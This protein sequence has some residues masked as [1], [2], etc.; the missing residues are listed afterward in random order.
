VYRLNNIGADRIVPL[1]EVTIRNIWGGVAG[2]LNANQSEGSVLPN[3]TRKFSIVWQDQ[4]EAPSQE[5]FAAAIS[6]LKHP[7]FGL[8][9]ADLH[10]AWGERNQ[11]SD[12]SYRFFVFPWQLALVVTVLGCFLFVLLKQYNRWIISR[13]RA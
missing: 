7:R 11:T 8:Y 12:A 5:F 2:T 4:T 6:Q 1:G 3:S 10:V 9:R 13:A